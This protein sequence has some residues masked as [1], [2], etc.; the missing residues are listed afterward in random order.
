MEALQRLVAESLVRNGFQIKETPTPDDPSA[1]GEPRL[2][3]SR[4]RNVPLEPGPLP[5]GF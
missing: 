2:N 4:E 1:S 5:W 3:L